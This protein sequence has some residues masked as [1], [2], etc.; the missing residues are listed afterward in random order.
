MRAKRVRQQA[1]ARSVLTTLLTDA[2]IDI[3]ATAYADAHIVE[4]EG[5]AGT[6]RI[7]F[8]ADLFHTIPGL[9]DRAAN[10]DGDYQAILD[11]LWTWNVKFGQ[12]WLDGVIEYEK[13]DR[14]S[15]IFDSWKRSHG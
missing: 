9:M 7:R 14:S 1:E 13:I 3:R 10:G 6:D 4:I 8:V 12:R 2:F 15:S 5:L 11:Q